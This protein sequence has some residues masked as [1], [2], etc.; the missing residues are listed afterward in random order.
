MD[1]VAKV[2]YGG[3]NIEVDESEVASLT[4]AGYGEYIS[5]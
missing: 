3:H 1:T 4:A 2:Y 5:G